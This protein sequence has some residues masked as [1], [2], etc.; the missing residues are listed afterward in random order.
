MST[1][2]VAPFIKEFYPKYYVWEEYPVSE[3]IAFKK[4]KEKWGVLGN[5]YSAPLVIEGVEFV[6]SEQLFQMMKFTDGQTLLSIYGARG[7]PIKWAA[8][9]GEKDGLCR[10]DWG[11]IIIDCMKFCLQTKYDQCEKF[12][13]TLAETTGFSIV[14]DQTSKRGK[15][16]TWGVIRKEDKY[17]G[18]N[19]MGR[20]LMELRDKGK[21]EYELP[22]DI[23]DFITQLK[24]AQR[25]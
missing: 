20:L 16:D 17:V 8:R 12:R 11:Q 23:F 1:G 13:K 10:S 14:E 24:N 7:L 15:A 9:K 19:L 22:A 3:C 18:S 2:K 25:L 4:V 6:N 5:F 21:L